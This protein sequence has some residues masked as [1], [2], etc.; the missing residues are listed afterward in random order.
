MKE[1]IISFDVNGGTM[2]FTQGKHDGSVTLA[3]NSGEITIPVEDMVRL[4]SHYHNCMDKG[5]PIVLDEYHS[6][7]DTFI[8]QEV[9]FRVS[10]TGGWELSTKEVATVEKEAIERLTDDS[11][12]MFDYDA[13][14]DVI[15]KEVVKVKEQFMEE[16]LAGWLKDTGKVNANYYIETPK[17]DDNEYGWVAIAYVWEDACIPLQSYRLA[18]LDDGVKLANIN[19]TPC[20]SRECKL[21]ICANAVVKTMGLSFDRKKLD[22]V[23]RYVDRG[24]VQPIDGT[25]VEEKVALCL[26]AVLLVI[27]MRLGDDN[28][29]S[30]VKETVAKLPTE[31]G[32]ATEE[33]LKSGQHVF[34]AINGKPVVLV[35]GY[36]EESGFWGAI[37]G[38]VERHYY[39]FDFFNRSWWLS[40]AEC[41]E[42]IKT[43]NDDELFLEETV[44]N[45]IKELAEDFK[46]ADDMGRSLFANELIDCTDVLEQG[47]NNKIRKRTTC[48]ELYYLLQLYRF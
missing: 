16:S 24:R 42:A 37:A 27:A 5:A 45:I 48:A 28:I 11:D 41:A 32:G 26:E 15:E 25:T 9:H 3:S 7:L 29:N 38:Y 43:A 40:E 4:A 35:V 2:S 1:R 20:L 47:G 21:R 22:N 46:V 8:E 23:V 19:S 6:A 36:V 10:E 18:L 13:I 39:S 33:T 30:I 14:D 12:V 34:V 44:V 31:V 17:Y